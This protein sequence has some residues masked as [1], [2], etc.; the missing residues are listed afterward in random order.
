[1]KEANKVLLY[2]C[3][4]YNGNY[5]KIFNAIK[6]REIFDE[7]TFMSLNEK[8]ATNFITILDEEY[9]S[10]LNKILNCPFVLFYKGDISLLKSENKIAV[11]GSRYNS[12]YGEYMTRKLVKDLVKKGYVIVSGLAKG[13]DSIAHDE[14]LKNNGKTIAVMGGGFNH[15]YPKENFELYNK[16]IENGLVISEYPDFVKPSA[17]KFPFRNRII[18]GLGRGV[19]VC[20]AK[21]HSGSM[22]TV[23]YALEQGK[24]VY[25]VPYKA[26]VESG[27]NLLIKEGAFL[28]E[29]VSD[30]FI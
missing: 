18:A 30:I 9:P 26:G 17:D 7:N 13:I 28:I 8:Q 2:F 24:D 21:I 12:T 3:C 22:I 6:E 16:I 20:E 15:I 25:C 14:A 4:F 10:E 1:M 27:C 19:V 11:V 5:Q 23:R 29:D